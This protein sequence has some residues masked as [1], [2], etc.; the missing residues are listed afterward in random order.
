[1]IGPKYTRII[2]S[3]ILRGEKTDNYLYMLD[4][5]LIVGKMENIGF[6]ILVENV[7]KIDRQDEL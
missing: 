3:M 1:M 6:P 7:K 4:G 2:N 5:G